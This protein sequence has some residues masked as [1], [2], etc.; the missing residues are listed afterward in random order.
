MQTLKVQA[1]HSYEVLIGCNWHQE[2][3]PLIKDRSRVAIV[4]SSTMRSRVGSINADGAEIHFFEIPDGEAGKDATV[5]ESLWHQLGTTGFTRSDLIVAIG[6]GATTDIAG[7]AAATW[8]RGIDW[9]AIPTTL[10]GMVDASIGGK[11]GMNS[12]FGKNL[13]G[14]FHSPIAVLVDP[15][16]LETLGDRDFAAGLAE[17]VKCGFIADREILTLLSGKNLSEIRSSKKLTEELILRSVKIKADV[18]GADF[19]EGFAREVLN[20]GHTMGHAVELHSKYQLRHGEAVSVGL[21][22]VAELALLK[23]VLSEELVALHRSLLSRLGL[24]T[25]YPAEAWDDLQPFL[26]LDKKARGK[27]LRFVAI[28]KIGTTLRLEGIAQSDLLKAYERVSS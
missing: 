4:V 17:V 26:S 19:K 16:W 10:A 24:P 28:S 13:V 15:K 11:T 3:E 2:L 22:Y 14:A 9:I 7:F 18:V 25:T 6:G 12:T 5:L 1:E 8:L 21:M 27:S 23:G 20:Y